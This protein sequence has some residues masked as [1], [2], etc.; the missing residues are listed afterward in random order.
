MTRGGLSELLWWGAA[1]VMVVSVGVGC[2]AYCAKEY[3]YVPILSGSMG[4]HTPKGALVVTEPLRAQDMKPGDV[5]AFMPP[6]PWTPGD[7]LPMVHRIAAV[8]RDLGGAVHM[9]TKGDANDIPDPW[10]IDLTD[11]AGTYARVVYQIP[12]LGGWIVMVRSVG[13]VAGIGIVTG[14]V[15]PWYAVKRTLRVRRRRSAGTVARG[16]ASGS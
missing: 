2:W 7:G 5:V 15:M 6:E 13:L 12:Y 3:R 8:T 11:G 4:P 16:T 1:I 9:T 14:V 10:Q